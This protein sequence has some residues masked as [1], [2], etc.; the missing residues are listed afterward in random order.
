[1]TDNELFLEYI[2]DEVK[3]MT[4]AQA[5]HIW[6]VGKSF[7]VLMGATGVEEFEVPEV[8]DAEDQ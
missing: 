8:S 6:H 7:T 1:M 2:K 3:G 4:L 5:C